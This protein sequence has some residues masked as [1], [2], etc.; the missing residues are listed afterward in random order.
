MRRTGR[1]SDE[2]DARTAGQLSISLG[3][4]RGAGFVPRDDK[5]DGS[6]TESVEDGDVTLARNAECGVDAVSEELVDEDHRPATRHSSIGS[7][8]K[9]LAR[10]S[11]GLS[12]SAGST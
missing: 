8:K 2:T 9:T 10:C 12:S 1:P 11:L 3:H 7:S 6:V 5:A 4:V